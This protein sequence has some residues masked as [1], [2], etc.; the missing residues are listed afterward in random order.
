MKHQYFKV[1]AALGVVA[2]LVGTSD[3][4]AAQKKKKAA[5]TVEASQQEV[6]PSILKN[7]SATYYGDFNGP[8][9]TKFDTNVVD[10]AGKKS[11]PLYLYNAATLSYSVS[12]VTSFRVA[13]RWFLRPDPQSLN[14]FDMLDPRVGVL[15]KNIV[16]DGGFSITQLIDFQLGL[17]DGA[18]QKDRV[19][20]PRFYPVI[21]YAFPN[22]RWSI[23]LESFLQYHILNRSTQA[24][25]TTIST[26]INP[27][28]VYQATPEIAAKVLFESES[29]IEKTDSIPQKKMAST[30]ATSAPRIGPQLIWNIT[31]NFDLDPY[32]KFHM[33][34]GIGST[35]VDATIV[36][37]EINAKFF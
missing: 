27:Y 34:D 35:D 33:P 16:Q 31:P 1:L 9:V 7:F 24:S 14:A 32:L 12:P 21:A 18:R 29:A 26:F 22:S 23:T 37:L 30:F 15:F 2:T 25:D 4:L 3:A 28:I 13:P 11:E 19:I 17:T 6:Q 8:A 20:S 36:G 5:S 10:D